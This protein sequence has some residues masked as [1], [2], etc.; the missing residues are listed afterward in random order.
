[1]P[2]QAYTPSAVIKCP[3]ELHLSPSTVAVLGDQT[4]ERIETLTTGARVKPGTRF[5][6]GAGGQPWTWGNATLRT[7]R[8]RADTTQRDY[9]TDLKTWLDWAQTNDVDPEQFT[10]DDVL[11]FR[12]DRLDVDE[13]SPEAWNRNLIALATLVEV[14]TGAGVRDS[15]PWVHARD[16][17]VR[18]SDRPIRSVDRTTYIRFRDV[19]MRGMALDGSLDAGFTGL[20]GMRDGLFADLLVSTGMRRVEASHLLL[21]DLPAG[22]RGEPVARGFLP[23]VICK[24]NSG[25][26]FLLTSRWRSELS[27]YHA[28]EWLNLV[29]SSQRVYATSADSLTT[30]T[31]FD[32]ERG[33]INGRWRRMDNLQRHVRLRLVT[34]SDVARR[35]G[36]TVPD[37]WLVPLAVFP[38]TRSPGARP[39]TWTTIFRTASLRTQA[40]VQRA[41]LPIV[42]TRVTPHMLRHTFA[43]QYLQSRM[44]SI[45]LDD[46]RAA[47]HGD[48]ERIKRFLT[49]P[50][51]D[52][53]NLLGHRQMDTTLAYLR[54]VAQRDPLVELAHTSWTDAFLSSEGSDA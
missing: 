34:T 31:D 53:Q 8:S 36:L 30:V 9:S 26:P 42:T 18:T 17:R 51:M 20:T 29:S 11:D 46:R 28:T 48:L 6:L 24:N 3:T 37:G 32:G 33:L 49:N 41:G 5:L 54:E 43:T 2:E 47:Q 45:S 39:D 1:M 23:G 21:T 35:L 38:G 40:L 25:R 12:E 44:D 4:V 14:L 27:D 10:P 7:F 16:L 15:R 52:L 22:K 13:V 50:L 19:G